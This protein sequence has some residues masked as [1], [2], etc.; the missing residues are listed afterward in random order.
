MKKVS[1]KVLSL[2][3]SLV[4]IFGTVTVAFA[5]DDPAP[6]APAVTY[7]SKYF[8]STSDKANAKILLDKVDAALKEANME[9]MELD[10]GVAKIT[11][12]FTSVDGICGTIDLVKSV[13]NL[14][15]TK[16]LVGDLGDNLLTLKTEEGLVFKN[17]PKDMSRSKTGDVEIINRVI[18]LIADNANVIAGLMDGNVELGTLGNLLETAGVNI[19][20]LFPAG[21]FYPMIQ[22]MLVQAVYS[23]TESQAYKDAIA[24]VKANGIDAFVY[25]DMISDLVGKDLLPGFT[26]DGKTTFDELLKS[27]FKI[28]WDNYLVKL[29]ANINVDWSESDNEALKKLGAIMNL[30]GSTID[31]ANIPFDNS[32]SFSA[33]I[34]DIIG[35]MAVQFFPGY[36]GWKSG[37][38]GKLGA[39]LNSLYLYVAKALGITDGINTSDSSAVA[40]AVVKY[41]LANI[42]SESMDAYIEGIDAC[43]DLKQVAVVVLRNTAAIN[44]IPVTSS[45]K[46]TYENILGDILTYY[47]GKAIVLPYDA[48]AGKNVWT[49]LNDVANI[50][51]YDKGFAKILKM[52]TTKDKDIFAKLD[53]LIAKT[54]LFDNLDSSYD[55]SVKAF[56]KDG[57][58]E[59][60]FS[61]DLAKIV[62]ITVSRF[63]KDFSTKVVANVGY[64]AIY[65]LLN[66]I[67]GKV[68][69]AKRNTS[70]DRPLDDAIKNDKLEAMIKN[71]LSSLNSKKAS[72]VPAVAYIGAL[73]ISKPVATYSF[74]AGSQA[75]L[76]GEAVVPLTATAVL[77]GKTYSLKLG[78]DYDVISTTA[79]NYNLGSTV[80]AKLKVYGYADA[81]AEVTYKIILGAVENLKASSVTT[82]SAVLTWDAVP[83]AEQYQ[84]VYNNKLIQTVSEPTCKLS[85]S[86]AT[87]YKYSVRAIAGSQKGAYG[88]VYIITLPGKA[89]TPTASSITDTSVKL[90]WKAVSGAS[91]YVVEYYKSGKWVTLKAV[92]STK[93]TV[94]GLK[95]KS[96][97]Y[98]RVKA[99]K[100]GTSGVAYGA[101][102]SYVKVNTLLGAP[103]LVASAA[104]D[105]AIKVSWGKVSGAAGYV[106]Q[107]YDGKKWV[108]VKVTTATT[109]TLTKLK[110]NT[111]YPFRAV[112]YYKS[113]S[114]TVYGAYSATLSVSTAPVKTSTVK[115]SS[116]TSSTLTVSWKAVSGASGYKVFYSTNNKSWKSVTTTKTS[117]TLT[118]LSAN[119]KY[120]VKVQV[121]KKTA[122]IY[123]TSAY[124]A[125]VTG[126]TSV[127]KVSG[128]KVKGTSKNAIALSWSKVSGASG[129]T[130]YRLSGK[131]WVKVADVKTNSYTNKGLSRSTSYTYCVAAYKT[132]SKKAVYGDQSASVKAKTK[133]F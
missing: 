114:K 48:G 123:A 109:Y 126:A 77:D 98:F 117:V 85:L 80:T 47:V 115:I 69:L 105:N 11:I 120:Y 29:I 129:Y 122:G 62:D 106:L 34:N 116:P 110:A 124:S 5:A 82:N 18:T 52:T 101:E 49:V 92:T 54:K 27:V 57:L 79:D 68:I 65:N 94:S 20:E 91:G 9:K 41:I 21:G 23:D 55:Y 128:L 93:Y 130:V 76:G 22:D 31:T 33:Q 132:V 3:L 26:M 103:K 7:G 45:T 24:K 16:E 56:V 44:N 118:K 15:G 66:G 133:F 40:F 12:D 35:Y 59:A 88:S 107:R 75:C 81:E 61:L 6:Q 99:Y 78:R 102:S 36:T 87:E 37:D 46:A 13:W 95:A 97:Y 32:K 121:L 70:S 50:F 53:E 112:A 89:S 113:G 1:T 19:N 72:L 8:Q 119:T 104:T 86:A 38:A 67:F 73:I 28:S 83:G 2:L 17:W 25:E 30:N 71:L 84:V 64:D 4:L 100:K 131:K 60:V 10:F 42:E 127:A 58:L 90:S 51:L 108:N 14:I 111:T 63:L 125:T 96:T 39:N 43:K 74:S